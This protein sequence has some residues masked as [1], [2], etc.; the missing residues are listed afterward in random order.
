VSGARWPADK[1]VRVLVEQ[2]RRWGWSV[3]KLASGHAMVTAPSGEFVPMSSSPSDQWS[4][5]RYRKRIEK[6][7]RNLGGR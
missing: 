7:R 4:V 2:C 5:R 3:E 1:D 6:I